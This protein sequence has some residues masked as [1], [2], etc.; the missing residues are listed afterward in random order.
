MAKPQTS[1]VVPWSMGQWRE[2]VTLLQRLIPLPS[3]TD[4]TEVRDWVRR[5]V[6]LASKLESH[7]PEPINCAVNLLAEIAASDAVW[8][9]FYRLL[10]SVSAAEYAVTGS[11]DDVRALRYDPQVAGLLRELAD[12]AAEEAASPAAV[13]SFDL[14]LILQIIAAIIQLLNDRHNP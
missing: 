7:L 12:K 1:D 11:L 9:A 4:S 10:A 6:A 8:A 13:Q 2:I 3:L 14:T 5:L